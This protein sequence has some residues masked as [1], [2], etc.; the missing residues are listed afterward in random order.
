MKLSGIVEVARIIE[1]TL[2]CRCSRDQLYVAITR[3]GCPDASMRV[4]GRKAFTED[5]AEAII[6]WYRNSDTCKRVPHAMGA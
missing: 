1:D 5:G 4:S 6:R 3:S 2:N